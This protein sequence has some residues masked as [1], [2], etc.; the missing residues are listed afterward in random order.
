MV[1]LI[2]P[3]CFSFEHADFNAALLYSIYLAFPEYEILF[4]GEKSH[5]KW[6]QNMLTIEDSKSVKKINWR[7]IHIPESKVAYWPRLK[8]EI[9]FTR[10]LYDVL[11]G[12]YINAIFLCSV[13]STL[14]LILKIW[15]RKK[16]STP[17]FA[18]V[19]GVLS[20]VAS[21][22]PRR[23]W[24]W[25]LSLRNVLSLPHPDQL[26]YIIPGKSIYNS[27]VGFRKK[28]GRCFSYINAPCFLSRHGI[29]YLQTKPKT[30]RFGYTGTANRGFENF[31]R[32]ASEI[33][34][35]SDSAKFALVG[36]LI[37]GN[38]S[39]NYSQKIIGLTNKTLSNREYAEHANNLTYIVGTANPEYYKWGVHS[40]L[41]D[42]LRYIK[43]GIYIR[44]PYIEYYFEKV[45]NIG[46]LCDNYEQVK[47]TVLCI[48][49][50]FPLSKYQKQCENLIKGRELFKPKCVANQI[51]KIYQT[52]II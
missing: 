13:T 21:K 5:I 42:S 30:I 10:E 52:K 1:V 26:H 49:H 20:T 25:L 9:E 47:Q 2:E 43:P 18:V 15:L 35:I 40:T 36:H 11:K 32:L 22:Q 17:I 33:S 7:Q 4:I 48:V 27:I 14:I 16:H 29:D 50:D 44:N 6:V 41:L 39:E 46:Y 28:W 24:N 38:Q 23:P 8:K 12:K 3:Q 34:G 19:H 51:I 45:G 37:D 31:N